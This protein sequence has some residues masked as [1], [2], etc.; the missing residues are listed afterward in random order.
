MGWL[1]IQN[2]WLCAVLCA[3]GSCLVLA[4]LAC[5]LPLPGSRPE[6]SPTAT[7]IPP[8]WL[9]FPTSCQSTSSAA[10]SGGS[11]SRL[12]EH[13]KPLGLLPQGQVACFLNVQICGDMFSRSQ[14]INQNAGEK[15]PPELSAS[16]APQT[17]ICCPAWQAA[18]SSKMPCDPLQDTDC[19]GRSNAVDNYLLDPSR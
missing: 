18:K 5:A 8:P 15:C 2:K 9:S 12:D 16:H 3:I 11:P 6:A 10:S 7:P 4:A 13:G 14:V 19:D 1:Y 17:A